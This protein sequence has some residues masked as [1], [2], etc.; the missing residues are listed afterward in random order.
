MAMSFT[1]PAF[2]KMSISAIERIP[3][4]TT[5]ERSAVAAAVVGL[6]EGEQAQLRDGARSVLL[7][8]LSHHHAQ[9]L[10]IDLQPPPP[11]LLADHVAHG[12]ALLGDAIEDLRGRCLSGPGHPCY[13]DYEHRAFCASRG[14]GQSNKSISRREQRRR[15]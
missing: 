6:F 10:V 9:V 8:Q 13:G 1:S 12:D 11:R 2:L 5:T 14:P 7:P 4:I 3:S 15:R